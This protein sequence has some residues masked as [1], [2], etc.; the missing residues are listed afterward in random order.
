MDNEINLNKNTL[1]YKM[2]IVRCSGRLGGVCLGGVYPGE[3]TSPLPLNRMTDRRK[4]ITFPQLRL[5]TLII[6]PE[7]SRLQKTK[8]RRLLGKVSDSPKSI[9]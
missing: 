8:T 1:Q 9:D 2:R 4:N 6:M 3:C 5:R 7:Y